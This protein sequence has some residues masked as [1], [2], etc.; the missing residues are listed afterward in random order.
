MMQTWQIALLIVGLCVG[1]A[2]IWAYLNLQRRNRL[3]NHFGPEYERTINELGDR[4]RAEKE[5]ARR[6]ARVRELHIRP[7]S[8]SDRERFQMEW[9]ASQAY[10]V[11]DPVRAVNEADRIVIDMMRARGY[12]TDDAN[13]RLENISAAYPNV[14]G[15]Y[16]DACDILHRYQA[17][18]STTEDLR[19]AMVHYREL[20]DELMGGEHEELKRAS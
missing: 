10:F 14:T 3:R 8:V 4:R 16:R 18:Q 13:E 12:P 1:A 9:R 7:W 19:L 20:F 15:K 17:G 6:E 5:L 2:V 11:D